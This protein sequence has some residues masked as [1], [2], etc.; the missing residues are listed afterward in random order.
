MVYMHGGFWVAGAKETAITGLLPWLEMGWNVVN[1]EYRLGLATDPTTLAPAAVDDCFC[2]LR[3]VA[4]L[5]ANYNI[6]KNRIVVTGESA[7]GHLALSMGIIPESTG[8][9]RECAGAAA[10]P[11]AA[12]ARGGAPAGPATATPAAPGVPVALPPVPRVAAVINWYGITDVPDVID[13]TNRQ[14]AAVRWFGGMP[15]ALDIAKTVSPLTYVRTGLPP[16]ITIHGDAD[17]T[18]P[19]PEAVRLHEALAK[20]NVPNQLI[21]VPNGGH[22]GFSA[23]ERVK[24]YTAIRDFLTKNGVMPK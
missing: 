9:G 8:L 16:I 17:R 20:V 4:A 7:G 1:V 19:Y 18:V 22:G 10:P 13:G 12:G 5:P 2:A 24:V 23:E 6:D 3:F 11:P 15:N 21:T 14:A